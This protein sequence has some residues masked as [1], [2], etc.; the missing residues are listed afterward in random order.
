MNKLHIL[1]IILV[2]FVLFSCKKNDTHF[3]IGED[4]GRIEGPK[5]WTLDTDSIR[6]SFAAYQSVVQ[7]YEFVAKVYVTGKVAESDRKVGISVDA[8]GTTASNS[9]FE[10]PNSVVIPKNQHY[11]LLP[12]KIKRTAD[13][14]QKAVRLKLSINDQEQIKPGTNEW[15]SLNVIWSDILMK[16]INW[17]NLTEF[18][19]NYSDTKY[20]FIIDVLQIGDFT[21]G[22]PNGMTWGQMN[23][24]RLRVIQALQEYNAAHPGNP[25]TDE[26]NQLVTF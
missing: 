5:E 10:F 17:G 6:F 23:Y 20:R 21:Y 15:N 12:I 14:T 9:Q 26:N 11:A 18:F 8:K 3:W 16:P 4:Y 1:I 7:D 13:L 22:Q 19:T 24:Y 2:Q 25:L